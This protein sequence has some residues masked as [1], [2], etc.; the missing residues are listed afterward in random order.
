MSDWNSQARE[1]GQ[2]HAQKLERERAQAAF[3]RPWR[4][5]HPE[6]LWGSESW[7][8][9]LCRGIEQ[10][11]HPDQPLSLFVAAHQTMH[12]ADWSAYQA[13][14]EDGAAQELGAPLAEQ[15]ET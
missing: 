10:S 15:G 5:E 2:R 14:G 3:V 9:P 8:C 4:E 6:S 13:L 12:G 7:A 11:D 1:R